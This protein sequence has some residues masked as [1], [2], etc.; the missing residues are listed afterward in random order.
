MAYKG[1]TW[2]TTAGGAEMLLHQ[3]KR[4]RDGKPLYK[5]DTHIVGLYIESLERFLEVSP[6]GSSPTHGTADA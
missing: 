2:N 1:F 5:I 3:L 6:D 4:Y